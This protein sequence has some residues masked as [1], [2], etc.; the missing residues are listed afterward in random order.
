MNRIKFIF[1]VT[2]LCSFLLGSFTFFTYNNLYHY[3]GNGF[4]T[5]LTKGMIFVS[6]NSNTSSTIFKNG[7]NSIEIYYSLTPNSHLITKF[8]R[9]KWGTWNIEGW[10]KSNDSK[11]PSMK[12]ESLASGGTDWEYVFRV[13]ET[14]NSTY[15]F[16]GGN[17]GLE[18][19]E[20]I[21]F[22][23][24]DSG[25]EI[26]LINQKPVKVKT[27]KIVEKT[28][29]FSDPELKHKYASVERVYL[30]FP[31][32]ILLDTHLNFI[33]DIYMGTSYV[34]MFPVSK[35]NGRYVHFKD[36]RKTFTTPPYG[37]T[38]TTKIFPNYIGKESTLSAQIWGDSI[39]NLKFNIWIKSREMVDH[40]K[41][42]LKV[43]YWDVNPFGNKLY[44]SKYDFRDYKIIT[45]GTNWHNSSGW[46]IS[47]K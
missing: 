24:A 33:S 44:F 10:Y 5:P 26:T 23:D 14:A 41:N 6:N 36:I 28:A 15:K 19:L 1:T 20:S 46:E 32:K 13:K 7:E 45:S 34:C 12:Q 9:T 29:L 30:V 38:L 17:H 4:S 37:Q 18:S 2:L 31:Y 8:V 43:F 25:K 42:E 3:A 11:I 47:F 35:R 27:L 21:K 39:S 22:M 16:S 40:F